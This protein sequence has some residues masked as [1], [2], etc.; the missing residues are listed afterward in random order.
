MKT[1]IT[2]RGIP[3]AAREDTPEVVDTLIERH[4]AG[5]L[6]AFN[7]AA[8]RLHLTIER[9]ERH[10]RRYRVTG[11]LHLPLRKHLIAQ[12]TEQNL[13]PAL[14]EVIHELA[15]QVERHRA[16]IRG[17]RAWKRKSRR[18][19]LRSL[20]TQ[21]PGVSET[22]TAQ[23]SGALNAVLPRVED[24]LR[25]ELAWLRAAGDLPESYP[26]LADLRD[27]L[28]VRIQGNWPRL[29]VADQDE[30]YRTALRVGSDILDEETAHWRQA[31]L[32]SSLEAP[33]PADASDQAEAMVGEEQ[34]EYYQPDEALHLEDII[35]AADIA[36]PEALSEAQATDHAYQLLGLLPARW[37]R[38]L[39]LIHRAGLTPEQAAGEVLGVAVEELQSM[40]RAAEAFLAAHRREQ[41]LDEIDLARLLAPRE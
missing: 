4:L 32:E 10:G 18:E 9:Q 37:R 33:P 1:D 38:A 7:P 14:N 21:Q 24:H 6:D 13:H 35:P 40:L 3:R 11:R 27:E 15:R 19:Q 34:T 26:T 29:A 8:L 16:H 5:P 12:A 22:Q 36:G 2:W 41:G 39:L 28:F 31:Q 25:H 23:A 30:L 17:Q 20:K